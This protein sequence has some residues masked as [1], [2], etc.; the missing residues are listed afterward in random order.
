MTRPVWCLRNDFVMTEGNPQKGSFVGSLYRPANAKRNPR[1]LARGVTRN[2]QSMWTELSFLSH[3][4]LVTDY[5]VIAWGITTTN[6]ICQIIDFQGNCD[7]CC[8][9]VLLL[10]SPVRKHLALLGAESYRSMFESE[11]EL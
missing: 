6:L 5:F 7:P 11:A 4:F 3:L 9:Y 8:Y 1:S 10:R 2:G